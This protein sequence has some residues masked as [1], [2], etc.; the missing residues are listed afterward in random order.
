MIALASC[1][2]LAALA[3][4]LLVL[5]LA[6]Q[7]PP[8]QP[9][10]APAAAPE[11]SEAEQLVFMRTPLA[12]M[13]P[14]QRLRYRYRLEGASVKQPVDDEAV[15]DLSADSGGACC[16][17]RADFLSGPRRMQLPVVEQARGN[18]VVLFFLEREVRRLSELTKGSTNHFRKRIRLALVDQATVTP[19]EFTFAG[20]S[21]RGSEVR[22]QPFLQDP[23]RPRY[24][25]L[26]Q[27]EYVFL[28]SEQVPG[29]VLELRATQPGAT[30]D[31]PPE[32]V[33]R[34]TLQPQATP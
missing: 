14:P 26:A 3:L 32:S 6:A 12:A 28:L 33:E 8:V 20:R 31:A 30:P 5:P 18:P 24:E 15:L 2:R 1:R 19:R 17:V 13:Q 11:P 4:A 27:T 29:E 10:A 34:L 9:E 7:T 22:V 16:D 23:N 21:V 25:K